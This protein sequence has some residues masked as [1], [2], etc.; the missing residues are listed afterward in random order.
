MSTDEKKFILAI[1]LGTSALKVA[2]VTTDGRVA[3]CESLPM[4]VTLLSGGGA[5][6]DPEDWWQGVVCATKSLLQKNVVPLD[7]VVAVSCS[8]QWSGTVAVDRDS[9]PL[10]PAIVW[11]DSRGGRY[12]KRLTGGLI[13]IEGYGLTRLFTWVR[14]TEGA[15]AHSGKDPIAHIVYIK[16]RASRSLCCHL[17]VS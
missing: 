9:R 11:M 2:L 1:D 16:T 8:A 3:A 10:M 12:V 17:Q 14:L 15:P 4:Q 5:E 6:Q 13:E 7:S